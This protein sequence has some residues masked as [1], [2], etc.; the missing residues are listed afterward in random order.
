MFN[1]LLCSAAGLYLLTAAV[2]PAATIV[3]PTDQPTI[4]AGIDA[5]LDQDTVLVLPGTYSGPGN[6]EI[7][8]NAR[9]V[10]LIS[11]EGAHTT[12]I[13]CAGAG[14]AFSLRYSAGPDPVI[15]GFTIMNGNGGNQGGAIE[16]F[17]YSPVI[18]RCVFLNNTAKFGG[19]FY[20]NGALGA[21]KSRIGCTPAIIECTFVGNVATEQGGVCHHN[22]GA[23]SYFYRSILSGN[24]SADDGPPLQI[25]FGYGEIVLESYDIH[26]NLPGDYIGAI[27]E[28]ADSADNFSAPPNFCDPTSGDYRLRPGSSCSPDQSPCGHLIGALPVGC[29][30]CED[31]DGD[32]MCDLFDNCIDIPNLTQED[33]DGDGIGDVCDDPDADSVADAY[34]NCRTTANPLQEDGDTD[35]PGD[36]CDNCPEV[37]NPSQADADRDGLGDACDADVDGDEIDNVTITARSTTIRNN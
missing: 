3:V 20:F 27:S 24:V 9:A 36:A 30:P 17:A 34:D 4:Q 35:G 29:L 18:R 37:V 6:T 12:I 16:C 11:L 25:G 31:A 33:Y 14:R 19:A 21:A 8:F 23:L 32:Q 15:D 7:G 5:A 28:W 2:C 22:Y 1:R 26:G 10:I 13:D